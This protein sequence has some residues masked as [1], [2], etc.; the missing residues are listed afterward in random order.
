[1]TTLIIFTTVLTLWWLVG[2]VTIINDM[3]QFNDVTL[4]DAGVAIVVGLLGPT[5]ILILHSD[6]VVFKKRK[7]N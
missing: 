5:T 6:K 3:R 7:V 1:M 2:I 4:N